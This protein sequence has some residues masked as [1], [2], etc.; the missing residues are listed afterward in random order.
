MKDEF[1]TFAPDGIPGHGGVGLV[2]SVF[3]ANLLALAVKSFHCE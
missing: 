1:P 3:F 2:D